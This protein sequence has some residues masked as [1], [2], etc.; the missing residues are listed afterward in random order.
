MTDFRRVLLLE[1]DSGDAD[2]AH[3]RESRVRSRSGSTGRYP[4]ERSV[5]T[6]PANILALLPRLPDDIQYRFLGPHLVIH[7]TRA[8]MVLDRLPCAIRCDD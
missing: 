1:T 6:V 4:K 7:D 2:G 8:N 3:G 5:S